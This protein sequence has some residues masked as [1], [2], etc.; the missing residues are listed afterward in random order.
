[1]QPN[2]LFLLD[3]DARTRA[4]SDCLIYDP[5]FKKSFLKKTRSG[6]LLIV[7]SNSALRCMANAITRVHLARLRPANLGITPATI[8]LLTVGCLY[9]RRYKREWTHAPAAI[10][11]IAPSG[12]SSN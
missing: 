11:R 12:G 6:A 2:W 7:N 10:K 9:L 1:L 5:S 4:F 8:A 3:L